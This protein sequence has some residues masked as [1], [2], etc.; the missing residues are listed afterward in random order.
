VYWVRRLLVLG[1][2]LG[3]VFGIAQL[4]GKDG[5]PDVEQART[6]VDQPGPKRQAKA[7]RPVGTADAKPTPDKARKQQAKK[8]RKPKP[9]AEPSGPCEREDIVATPQV[10]GAAYAGGLVR[11]RVEL[12]TPGTPACTWTA[13][14][15]SMVLKLTSGDD[16]IWSS[17]ECPDAIA[18]AQVVVRKRVPA[19]VL[20][21]WG[22]QR[23]DVTCSR[24]TAWA[25]AGWYHVEAAAYGAEPTDVQFE[26]EEPVPAT[27]TAKPDPKSEKKKKS[28]EPRRD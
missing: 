3:L 5:D 13:S 24:T 11:F 17:Q 16:R 26:L 25:E 28:D 2:A 27:V 1:V 4:L 18:T 15:T 6:V 9:L 22:G 7:S 20:V 12:T 8:D 10:A 19:T 14:A 21:T 23:S